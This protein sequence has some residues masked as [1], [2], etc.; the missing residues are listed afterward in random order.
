M[1]SYQKLKERLLGARKSNADRV[2]DLR[3][4]AKLSELAE[5]HVKDVVQKFG[6]DL[7]RT[8]K[9]MDEYMKTIKSELKHRLKQ[10]K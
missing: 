4:A 6:A 9:L 2:A 3:S 10:S 7:R 5:D 8:P 1:P